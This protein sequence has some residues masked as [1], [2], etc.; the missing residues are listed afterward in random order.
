MRLVNT[1]VGIGKSIVA[2]ISVSIFALLRFVTE[3]GVLWPLYRP[4]KI[5]AVNG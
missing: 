2:L 4:A 3:I 1:Y 5:R